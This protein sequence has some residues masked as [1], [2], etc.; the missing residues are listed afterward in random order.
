MS[1]VNLEVISAQTEDN[2]TGII[3]DGV[4]YLYWLRV[5]KALGIRADHAARVINR[6]TE[7]KHYI[8]Y[9][10]QEF[11]EKYPT[12]DTVSMV[13]SHASAYYFLTAEGLNR[14]VMEIRTCEMDNPEIA[15]AID[16]KKDHM[17]SI[18]AR[19]QKGEVLSL[20]SDEVKKELPGDVDAAGIIDENLAIAES[21]IKHICPHLKVDPG[22][23][24]SACITNAEQQIL[25]KGG[26]SNLEHLKGIIPRLLPGEPATLNATGIGEYFGI[27]SKRA[28]DLLQ[29]A[30]Y[31]E[32]QYRVSDTTGERHKEWIPTRK[33]EPHGEWKPV[34]K[35]HSNG[36]IH[37]GHKWYWKDSILNELRT[38]LFGIETSQQALVGVV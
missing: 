23:V 19:Y 3:I 10:K 17:A 4:P 8:R 31:H 38:S 36:S 28:N 24:T 27:S 34:T 7:G 33:G 1:D 32:P 25:K 30:G 22:L 15:A 2:L 18:Y 14:A 16:A 9:S 29:K 13:D 26:E 20:A 37:H 35:G 5:Y 21:F 12:I 11:K 6:L